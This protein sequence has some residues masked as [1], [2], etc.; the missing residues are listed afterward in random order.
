MLEPTV[1]KNT[2]QIN[3]LPP[4]NVLLYIKYFDYLS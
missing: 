3:I 1:K 4:L 2:P